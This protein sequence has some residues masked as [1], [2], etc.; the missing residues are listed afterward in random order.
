MIKYIA[1]RFLGLIPTILIVMTVIFFMMRLTP[2]GPFDSD[3][4]LPAEIQANLDARYNL[5]DPLMLQYVKWMGNIVFKFD[6]G[7]SLK[8]RAYTVNDLIAM[9]F[10]VSLLN[11]FCAFVIA[12]ALGVTFGIISALKKNKFWDH[13]FTSYATLGIS[14]PLFVIAPLLI[15]LFAR[16]LHIV[17]VAGWGT[18]ANMVVPVLA[19]SFPYMAYITRLTKAGML[20]MV[21]QDFVRTARSKGLP[22]G[23][24][25]RRH[26]L[27]GALIPVVSYIGPAFAGIVTGSMVVEQICSVPGM[28]RD[29]VLAAF[30]RD[31]FLVGGTAITYAALLLAMNFMVDIIYAILDPRVKYS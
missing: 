12:F 1:R 17:P 3:K 30:N 21:H 6:F 28:G 5:D 7:P 27:K 24:I 15:L 19:L 4:K 14:T 8:I 26:V 31:W 22:E 10:P 13:F 16:A 23:F 25:I 2:G 11:G 18:P 29:F 20:D 9:K